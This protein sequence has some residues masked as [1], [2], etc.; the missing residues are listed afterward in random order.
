M[1]IGVVFPQLEIGSDPAAI[2]D[3]VQATEDI[4]YAHLIMYDHILGMDRKHP[5]IWGGPYF[6]DDMFHEPLV[7]FGYMAAITKRLELVTSVL[8]LGQRQTA[9]VA[10]QA[11][12]IDVLSGGRL[13]LGVGNGY[14]HVEYRALSESFHNRGRRIEEQIMLLRALW[15]HETVNFEGRWH[16]VTHAGLNPLPVQRPIPIWIGAGRS[17][18]LTPSEVILRRIGRMADGWFTLFTP[19]EAGRETIAR[20]RGYAQE[21]GRDPSHIGMEARI[22]ITDGPPE[23]WAKQAKMWEEVGATHISVNTMRAGLLSPG[24][25]I[26]AIKQFKEVVDG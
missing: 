24:E 9:L 1:R 14:N 3:Y 17:P 11:A 10:K 20:M 25:H 5:E 26:D 21:A 22:N 18:N 12:E 16:R 6:S 8:I 2:R 19:D 13:R 7:A 15:T 23:H 4:G